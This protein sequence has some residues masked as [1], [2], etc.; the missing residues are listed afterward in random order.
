MQKADYILENMKTVLFA[1]VNFLP[2]HHILRLFY[3]C[4]EKCT[5]NDL[6]LITVIVTLKIYFPQQENSFLCV[7]HLVRQNSNTSLAFRNSALSLL[8]LQLGIL[9]SKWQTPVHNIYVRNAP[10]FMSYVYK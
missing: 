2:H 1:P 7:R 4:V 5:S 8:L 9:C 10:L 6:Y 3:F